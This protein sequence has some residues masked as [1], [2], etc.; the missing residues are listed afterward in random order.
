[1]ISRLILFGYLTYNRNTHKVSIPN[2]EVHQEFVD[3]SRKISKK[4]TIQRIKEC[5]KLF[6]DTINMNEDAV[7]EAIEKVH[8]NG[9][10][11]IIFIPKKNSDMPVLVIEL[12]WNNSAEGAIEQI[13]KRNYVDVVSE[14]GEEILLVGIS[15]DKESKDKKHYC[16]IERYVD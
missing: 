7:A 3:N 12:K 13:K 15:Y 9:F 14:Y 11:D 4:Y 1:M 5:D 8:R 6:E 16:R 10:A 2:E